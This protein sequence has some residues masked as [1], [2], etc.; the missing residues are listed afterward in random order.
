VPGA[1]ELAQ[2][3]SGVSVVL[4]SRRGIPYRPTSSEQAFDMLV[5]LLAAPEA[6]KGGR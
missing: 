3:R 5:T 1:E 6:A 2:A 4:T